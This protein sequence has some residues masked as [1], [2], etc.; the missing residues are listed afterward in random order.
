[1]KLAH[2]ARVLISLTGMVM[3]FIIFMTQGFGWVS[4]GASVSV[5]LLGGCIAEAVFRR[6]ADHETI[7][8]D[9]EDRTRNQF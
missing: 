9:L 5:L 3:G 6:V 2:S 8:R 4:I 1:M 7:R